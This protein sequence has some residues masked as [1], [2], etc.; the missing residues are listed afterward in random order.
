MWIKIED[1]PVP[2]YGQDGK[3]FK[4]FLSFHTYYGYEPYGTDEPLIEAAWDS[5][6]EY[7]F[8]KCTGLPVRDDDISMWWKED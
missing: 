5:L 2:T 7:F 6:N 3:L 1:E 8:E 4:L